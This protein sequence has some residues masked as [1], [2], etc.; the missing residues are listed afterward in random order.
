MKSLV[1]GLNAKLAGSAIRASSSGARL[2]IVTNTGR[3]RVLEIPVFPLLGFTA[4]QSGYVVR[5]AFGGSASFDLPFTIEA[6]LPLP[7]LAASSKIAVTLPDIT[8]PK[9]VQ[10]EYPNVSAA[11]KD[12]LNSLKKL[13]FASVVAGIRTGLEYLQNINIDNLPL[14]SQ[15][16]PLLGVNLRD[17][18]DLAV[19]FADFIVAFEKDPSPS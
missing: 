13:D 3:A 11:I 17:S 8:N 10:F 16:I 18:L 6:A 14:F 5:P 7:G 1:D 12:K 4:A 15:E 9:S 19:K 2:Q